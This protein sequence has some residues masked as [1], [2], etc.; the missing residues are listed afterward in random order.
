MAAV[1]QALDM[2]LPAEPNTTAKAGDATALWLG[3]DEWLL[4]TS[5]DAAP[6]LLESLR[7]AIAGQAAAV[8]DVGDAA[9]IIRLSGPRARDVLAK[10]CPL[11]LHPS[12]FA[13]GRVAQTIVAQA[14]AIVHRVDDG[15]GDGEFDVHVRRSFA[16][17]LW[18]WLAD[19]ALEYGV[20][21]DR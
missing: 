19:A 18:L 14:D 4:T 13:P 7:E 8:I 17:Y 16:E 9:T 20:G 5:A 10:G 6:A 2:V 11:D 15:S 21:V 1:G 12:V 3:P